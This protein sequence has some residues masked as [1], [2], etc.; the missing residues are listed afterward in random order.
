MNG[1]HVTPKRTE[2]KEK[3]YMLTWGD[4]QKEDWSAHPA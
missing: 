3:K 2:N 4:V 1:P